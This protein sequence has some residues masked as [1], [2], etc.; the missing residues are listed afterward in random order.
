M[1][2]FQITALADVKIRLQNMF[3]QS[4]VNTDNGSIMPESFKAI[5]ENQK[6]KAAPIMAAGTCQGFKLWWVEPS[7]D[8]AA[9][10][11]DLTDDLCDFDADDTMTL[12]EQDI[13]IT[14]FCDDKFGIAADICEDSN[15]IKFADKF[16]YELS[17]VFKR[18]ERKLNTLSIGYLNANTDDNSFVSGPM[19]NTPGVGT[20][21]APSNWNA[22]LMANLQQV[23]MMNKI[24]MPI[25]LNGSNLW[26]DIWNSQYGK[27]CGDQGDA[28]KF[29]SFKNWYWDTFNLDQTLGEKATF[30]WDAGSLAVLNEHHYMSPVPIEITADKHV[31]HV[32]HPTLRYMDDG[33]MKP[34]MIDVTRIR[35]CTTT[36]KG[37]LAANYFW[38]FRLRFEFL[39]SPVGCNGKLPLFKF[40]N[41]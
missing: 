35:K 19:T 21:I 40:L 14:N 9:C 15:I 30:M 1:A 33:K 23:S 13:E 37:T 25:L 24:A 4:R 6:I 38:H 11:G 10:D 12:A 32:A 36:L 34:L 22:G 3:T 26:V 20:I 5:A 29:M 39:K 16:A 31:Y 2:D 41:Q 28:A 8:D 27:C 18:Y 7:C 17:E